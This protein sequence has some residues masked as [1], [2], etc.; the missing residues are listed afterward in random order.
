MKEIVADKNLVSMCG[1]YCGACPK[2]LKDKC[3]GCEGYEK[4]TWCKVRTC[5]LQHGN[6]SCAD[7]KEFEDVMECKKFNNLFSRIIGFILRSDRAAC[8]EMIKEIG[9]EKFASYMA[10]NKLI[11]IHP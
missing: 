1:L 6:S 11:T 9:Y 3:P 4:A 2:Y 7:C 5:C 10:S 8:I